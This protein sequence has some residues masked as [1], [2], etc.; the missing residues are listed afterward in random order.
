M[1]HQL[2]RSMFIVAM[3]LGTATGASAQ[4]YVV[5]SWG[6]YDPMPYGPVMGE[7]SA[8]WPYRPTVTMYDSWGRIVDMPLQPKVL[9]YDTPFLTPQ[10]A[11]RPRSIVVMPDSR[12]RSYSVPAPIPT[13]V[14]PAEPIPPGTTYPYDGGPTNPV[15]DVATDPP[16]AKVIPPERP[17]NPIPVPPER[18]A[19]P[20]LIP[21]E[22]P[23]NPKPTPADRPAIPKVPELPEVPRAPMIDKPV[24]LDPGASKLGPSPMEIP[25]RKPG[26]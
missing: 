17:G 24:R 8:Y 21:P 9:Y 7:S 3:L 22:L 15:P 4:G 14:R 2:V 12:P 10:G 20:K 13:P 16:A 23:A 11:Y 25:L 26:G 6:Y 5:R 1:R 18:P 19:N